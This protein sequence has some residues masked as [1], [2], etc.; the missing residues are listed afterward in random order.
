MA[1][2]LK[3]TD[4]WSKVEENFLAMGRSV[5]RPALQL[6]YV[7]ISP[8]TPH[9]AKAVVVGALVYF[10]SPI[11]AIPDFIPGVGYVDDVGVMVLALGKIATC[12]DQEIL[13]KTESTLN[14]WFD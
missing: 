9:W 14:E 10:I 13:D 5:L 3:E 11:D 8:N 1:E 12:V 7:W 2:H 4:F 6:Y